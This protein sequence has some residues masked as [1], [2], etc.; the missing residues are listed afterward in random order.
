MRECS[1]CHLH[2]LLEWI[3]P[4]AQDLLGFRAISACSDEL[5]HRIYGRIYGRVIKIALR[6]VTRVMPR[7]PR[8]TLAV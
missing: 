8:D 6:S 4:E 5:I 1:R 3:P 7:Y 2:S